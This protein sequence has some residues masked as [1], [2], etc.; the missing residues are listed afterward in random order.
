MKKER[1]KEEGER[2]EAPKEGNKEVPVVGVGGVEWRFWPLCIFISV[3]ITAHSSVIN[4]APAT[5]L[6]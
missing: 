3:H 2:K 1:K 4:V 6:L 5:G